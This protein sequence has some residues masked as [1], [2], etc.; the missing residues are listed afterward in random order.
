MVAA[1]KMEGNYPVGSLIAL[2]RIE[3]VFAFH[4]LIGRYLACLLSCLHSQ[5][6]IPWV[7]QLMMEVA[8]EEVQGQKPQMAQREQVALAVAF[9]RWWRHLQTGPCPS[10]CFEVVAV[11]FSSYPLRVFALFLE[12]VNEPLLLRNPLNWKRPPVRYFA[13]MFLTDY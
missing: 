4:K 10:Y 1:G 7:C 3:V 11:G 6:Q 8:Q 2:D 5:E 9:V 12:H 13:A